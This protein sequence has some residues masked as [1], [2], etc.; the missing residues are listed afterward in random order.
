MVEIVE[1]SFVVPS[2]ETPKHSIWLSN[3]DLKNNRDYTPAV[4]VYRPSRGLDLHSTAG[5]LK[6]AMAKALVHFYPL[7]G[8]LE[9]DPD[10][11]CEIDCTGD[12]VLFVVGRFDGRVDEFGD[13]TP[14]PEM[15]RLLVPS[16][17]SAEP[18]SAVLFMVQV[19]AL[20]QKSYLTE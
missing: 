14:S 7:A 11:R 18:P 3:I 2:E 8:R 5:S 17:E 6:Q 15:R 13:F 19:S 20:F 12:G 1:T 10:G 16:V 4:Y 9:L